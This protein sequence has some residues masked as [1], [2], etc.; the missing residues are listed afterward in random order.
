LSVITASAMPT[1]KH[2]PPIAI[3]IAASREFRPPIAV[4]RTATRMATGMS[5]PGR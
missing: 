2:T 3:A 1:T 5:R 4:A